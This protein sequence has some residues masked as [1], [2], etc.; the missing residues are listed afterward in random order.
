MNDRIE[1]RIE[2]AA[3]T[4]RVWRALTDY[5]EFGKWFGVRLE[6]PFVAAR[7]FATSYDPRNPEQPFLPPELFRSNGS[8]VCLSAH[9]LWS[10]RGP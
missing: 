4:S 7:Q 3:P 2:L 10:P 9:S 1:K 8:W 6:G 5:L